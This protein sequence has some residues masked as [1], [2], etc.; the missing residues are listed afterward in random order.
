MLG[1]LRKIVGDLSCLGGTQPSRL[2]LG[3]ILCWLEKLRLKRITSI[4]SL[5]FGLLIVA[6]GGGCGQSADPAPRHPLTAAS[7]LRAK[8]NAMSVADR[9]AYIKQHPEAVRTVAG[10]SSM[11][12]GPK[13]DGTKTEDKPA[14][15]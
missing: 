15:G 13:A 2:P 10:G 9:L 1:I 8:L 6:L 7:Q 11:F 14:G 12:P 5:G 4:V 3:Y